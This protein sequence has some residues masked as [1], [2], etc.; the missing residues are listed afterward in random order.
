LK[1]IFVSEHVQ[2]L[3]LIIWGPKY[4]CKT[5]IIRRHRAERVQTT[6][7]VETLAAVWD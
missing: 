6:W 3:K 2:F 1:I 4:D 7:D 5:Y